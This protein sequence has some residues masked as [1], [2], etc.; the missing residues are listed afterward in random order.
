M[1]PFTGNAFGGTGLIPAGSQKTLKR[2]L[3]LSWNAY[4]LPENFNTS[5]LMSVFRIAL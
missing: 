3:V 1:K 4:L 2:R 5:L